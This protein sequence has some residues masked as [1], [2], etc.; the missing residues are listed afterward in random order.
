MKKTLL[1]IAILLIANDLY[2]CDYLIGKWNC[3]F[4]NGDTTELEI[5][6]SEAVFLKQT[7]MGI[8]LGP[9]NLDGKEHTHL[10]SSR[11]QMNYLGK[12]ENPYEINLT[13]EQIYFG[14]LSV[15]FDENFK[16]NENKELLFTLTDRKPGKP[17]QTKKTI[18]QKLSI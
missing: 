11:V 9:F 15:S 14:G 3:S 17:P 18:C 12:C 6:E 7:K 10:D 2:S 4:S 5:T 13:V 16:V 8:V 1:S